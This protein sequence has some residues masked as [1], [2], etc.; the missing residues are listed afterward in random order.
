METE[1]K[2]GMGTAMTDEMKDADFEYL[3]NI[4]TKPGPGAGHSIDPT[5]PGPDDLAQSDAEPVRPAW[6]EPDEDHEG[7][8]VV[9]VETSAQVDMFEVGPL[10]FA[11]ALAKAINGHVKLALAQSDEPLGFRTSDV[12]DPYKEGPQSDAE[13]V[14]DL[15]DERM[16]CYQF[17]NVQSDDAE[18]VAWQY[19][20]PDGEWQM[21][22]AATDIYYR[23]SKYEMRPLF[24]APPRPD[25]SAEI[26][27]LQE[28]C[29]KTQRLAFQW[30]ERHD[31]VVGFI[32]KN[33][34]SVMM[35]NLPFPSPVSRPDASA[36]LIE[37]AEWLEAN[38]TKF[39]ASW[40]YCVL[41]CAKDLRARAAERSGE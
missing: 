37:A 9:C 28:R 36:G 27:E 17:G 3:R 2:R 35:P 38:Q 11:D 8:Y 6:V 41:L 30:M 19:R 15:H 32:R 1:T 24:T 34:P 12:P 16:D 22:D 14:R 39:G 4:N 29:V 25:A 18:P 23:T 5:K 13:P 7:E 31:K 20:E 26:A 40:S 21:C 33:Y 10:H